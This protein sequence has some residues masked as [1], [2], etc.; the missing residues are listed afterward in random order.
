MLEA[1]FSSDFGNNRKV[2]FED[3]S[4]IKFAAAV[5]RYVEIDNPAFNT[6]YGLQLFYN[7]ANFQRTRTFE[8]NCPTGGCS[9]FQNH[10]YQMQENQ[11]GIRALSGLVAQVFGNL[12]AEL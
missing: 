7:Y 4:G 5:R 12:F 9:F 1:C 2:Y 6:Y 11:L 3:L 10:S 8:I